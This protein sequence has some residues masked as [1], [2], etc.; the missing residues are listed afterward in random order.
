MMSISRLETMFLLI[1]LSAC[2][3]TVSSNTNLGGGSLEIIVTIT[4]PTLQS[5]PQFNVAYTGQLVTALTSQLDAQNSGGTFSAPNTFT[6]FGPNPAITSSP[7]T[8]ACEFSGTSG[9]SIALPEFS[10]N[11]TTT[12]AAQT[13]EVLNLQPGSWT[14]AIV[15]SSSNP[16]WPL[17]Q[18]T[19]TCSLPIAPSQITTLTLG[20]VG[21]LGVTNPAFLPFSIV[22][23]ASAFTSAFSVPNGMVGDNNPMGC[24]S[25]RS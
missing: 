15:I 14:V 23:P 22:E 7:N 19:I 6:C 20:R 9:L 21:S 24:Q 5:N 1:V 12:T 25:N 8:L 11:S 18:D 4:G 3:A 2:S 13:V 10:Q 17:N 16:G